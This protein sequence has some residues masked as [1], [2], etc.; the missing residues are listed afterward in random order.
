MLSGMPPKKPSASNKRKKGTNAGTPSTV[1]QPRFDNIRFLGTEQSARYDNLTQRTIW[2]EKRFDI[3]EDGQYRG[4]A[5]IFANLGY[6]QLV[7]PDH[8]LH[9][10]VIREFYANAMPTSERE[11]DWK[12]W[13]R[14]K[15]ISFD[16][17]AINA[18]LGHPIDLPDTELCAYSRMLASG[19][20]PFE[21]IAQAI[22]NEGK[23]FEFNGAGKPKRVVREHLNSTAQAIL[24]FILN[25]VKPR[26]HVSSVTMD[27][28]GILFHIIANLQVDLAKIIANEMKAI[29]LSGIGAGGA[30]STCILA[31]PSLIMGMCVDGR[32]RIP[33]Q[34][35]ETID[36]IDDV[37]IVRYC[38]GDRNRQLPQP[39]Q[40]P[41]GQQ[42]PP[43]QPQPPQPPAFPH[44]LTPELQ[45][46]FIHNCEMHAATYKAMATV[47]ELVNRLQ[48][49]QPTYTLEEFYARAVW[50][51]DRPRFMG[52]A[53]TSADGAGV[54]NNDAEMGVDVGGGDDE[55]H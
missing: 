41:H 23:T 16:R 31:F 5:G 12:T 18:Y 52:G 29:V 32:V 27:F 50:P 44:P 55:N 43:I 49:Q 3:N 34:I 26:S 15:W 22:F 25:N 42:E 14:G 48:L 13:V 37:Y 19:N 33:P 2:P 30:K 40:A 53:S 36:T 17:E 1:Q 28:L 20:W 51:G 6:H 45:N 8:D 39:P 54:N 7:Q 10:G 4:I 21:E 11:F 35:D 38:K 9:Y 24:I 46:W 47:C